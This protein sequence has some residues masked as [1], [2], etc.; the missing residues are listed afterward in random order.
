V[1]GEVF[2]YIAPGATMVITGPV[3]PEMKVEIK[4][5]AYRPA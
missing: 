2:A 4:A 1:P 5:T 3:E